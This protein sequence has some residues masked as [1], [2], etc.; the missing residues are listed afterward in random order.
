MVSGD[1]YCEKARYVAATE[2]QLAFFKEWWGKLEGFLVQVAQNN[3]TYQDNCV[4][5]A[6]DPRGKSK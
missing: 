1:L 4:A 2:D 3:K 5:P 6:S